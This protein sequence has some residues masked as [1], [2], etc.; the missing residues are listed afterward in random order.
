MRK[1]DFHEMRVIKTKNEEAEKKIAAIRNKLEDNT[2]RID[3]HQ[4]RLDDYLGI[5]NHNFKMHRESIS[6]GTMMISKKQAEDI[7]KVDNKCCSIEGRVND[8]VNMI[9]GVAKKISPPINSNRK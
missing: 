9:A 4:E 2:K 5:V 1:S 7:C 8:C 3:T 6:R